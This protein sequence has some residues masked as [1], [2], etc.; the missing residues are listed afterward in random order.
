MIYRRP[1]DLV[2]IIRIFLWNTAWHNFLIR[3]TTQN[4]KRRKVRGLR[5]SY[6]LWLPDPPFQI[7]WAQVPV[8][9]GTRPI[10]EAAGMHTFLSL[11]NNPFN[12]SPEN[13]LEVWRCSLSWLGVHQCT[14]QSAW[15]HTL[16]SCAFHFI[17]ISIYTLEKE[18]IEDT[19][20]KY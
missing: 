19:Q 6:E 16:K 10:L 8:S 1:H 20:A 3:V 12:M 9:N 4:M 13:G 17:S 15:E 5:S 18:L 7:R 11:H 2:H 14:G